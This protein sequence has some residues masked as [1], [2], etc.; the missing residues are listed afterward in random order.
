MTNDGS[1]KLEVGIR[2]AEVGNGNEKLFKS[3]MVNYGILK[4]ANRRISNI[5]P[6]N[7]EG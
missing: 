2:N 4:I 6:Q 7:F 5:E 1:R 3:R